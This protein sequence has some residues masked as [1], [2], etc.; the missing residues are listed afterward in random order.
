MDER[1]AHGAPAGLLATELG[2]ALHRALELLP[3]GA[4]VRDV[5]A[6]LHAFALDDAQRRAA[7]ERAR[8]VL[9]LPELAPAFDPG[10]A[11]ACE[12]E[13]LDAA[14]EAR[15][16][17]RLARVGDETWILDWKWSVDAARRP[18]YVAQLAGYRALLEA[19]QPPPLGPWRRLRTVLVDATARRVSFDVDLAADDPDRSSAPG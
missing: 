7:I 2:H 9:A 6:A 15:R 19:L 1:D 11:S 8:A 12:F 18:D 14:G 3:D 10:A 16:I 17:D 4:D 13:I 5:E